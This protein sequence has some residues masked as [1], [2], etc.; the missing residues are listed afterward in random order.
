MVVAL[1]LLDSRDLHEIQRVLF[2]CSEQRLSDLAFDAR[3]GRDNGISL[4]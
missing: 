1:T 3:M 2:A 4:D